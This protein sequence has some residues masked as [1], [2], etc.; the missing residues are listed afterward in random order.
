MISVIVPVHN[1][2][3]TLEAA[4]RSVRE[5]TF[6]DV[7]LILVE[8]GGADGSPILCDTLAAEDARIRVF[9][10]EDMGVSAARNLGLDAARGERIAFLDADDVLHPSMLQVLSAMLDASGADYAGC[11]FEKRHEGE[12]AFGDEAHAAGLT[13]KVGAGAPF[14][15]EISGPDPVQLMTDGAHQEAKSTDGVVPM[16][17]SVPGQ[18]MS[19]SG[20]IAAA[21]VTAEADAD[22]VSAADL[23]AGGSGRATELCGAQIITEGTLHPE[24]P[25]TRVWSKLFSRE[26]IGDTRFREGLTIGE[27]ML[28]LVELAR[29]D[30]RYVQIPDALYSYYI[31]PNGAMER[32]FAPNHMD[33]IRCRDLAENV[34][35]EKFPGIAGDP[36]GAARL[37]AQQLIAAVLTAS[38]IARL[39]SDDQRRYEKEFETCRESIRQH[40][41]V[42]GA[43][44][45]LPKGYSVKIQM[46]LHLPG[47]YRKW[48]R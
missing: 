45:Y 14:P 22:R 43:A 1:A 9:H 28:F 25:D 16:E 3:G 36:D 31:N 15:A 27:D 35:R 33:T 7:E 41:R 20:S 5:Q 42:R 8:D 26:Y 48:Y 11:G 13:A 40:Y 30:A 39:P 12:A 37:A 2:A 23:E 29:P 46:L 34:I 10:M 32:P 24:H 21:E 19:G 6:A 47:V 17:S 44:E 38:K 18:M 4:V